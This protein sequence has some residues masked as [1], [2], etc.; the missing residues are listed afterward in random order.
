MKK[1]V[2]SG[3]LIAAFIGLFAVVRNFKQ[4]SKKN[5]TYTIG[6]L[7]TASHPAL[8]AARE[9]FIEE[10]KSKLG[11]EIEFVI[12]NAQGSVSQAHTIAQQFHANLTMQGVFAI[13][14][15]AAQ[16]MSS[17]EKAKPIFIAAVTD[18]Q[19][20][21]LISPL[22]NVCG[23]KDMIDVQ[24]EVDLVKQFAPGAKLVG[25]L[26]TSGETNSQVLVREMKRL[27]GAQGIETTDFAVSTEADMQAAM[28]SA[29]RKVDVILAPTDNAVASTIALTSSLACKY[30]KPFLVS[31]NMLVAA[32]PL[33]ARGVD[34]KECGKEAGK[35]AYKVLVEGKKPS[36]LPIEQIESKEVFVNRRTLQTLVATLPEVLQAEVIFVN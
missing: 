33:A 10:L 19:A 27:L 4:S 25:L 12:Q 11:D 26:Y 20:L 24:G 22:T 13:A 6:I 15:P 7:Q 30:K 21:G 17:V 3:V 36:D 16:A 5:V 14:T 28:E 35:V 9:G 32:G 23:S 29:C 1:L 34:Y 31:D 2:M 8:D 18:P